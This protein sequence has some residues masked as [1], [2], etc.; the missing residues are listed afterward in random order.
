MR[1]HVIGAPTP[2][3]YVPNI[4]VIPDRRLSKKCIKMRPK[5]VN[6]VLDEGVKLH[7]IVK[8]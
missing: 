1:G 8:M 3:T 4:G 5:N 6:L 7:D 2:S